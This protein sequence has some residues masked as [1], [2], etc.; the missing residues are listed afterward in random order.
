MGKIPPIVYRWRKCNVRIR[1]RGKPHLKYIGG[2]SAMFGSEHREYIFLWELSININFYGLPSDVRI[3]TWGKTPPIYY[4]RNFPHVRIRT[5]YVYLA[6]VFNRV[7]FTHIFLRG[8]PS[9]VR[10]RTSALLHLYRRNF[11]HV[12]MR[13]LTRTIGGNFA[14]CWGREDLAACAF[15]SHSHEHTGALR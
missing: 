9:S 11:P 14:L 3:R 2:E 6:R 1:T 4:R 7:L 13:T 5:S 15:V 12:R 8:V 10:I